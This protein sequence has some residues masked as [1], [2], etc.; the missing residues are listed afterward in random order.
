MRAKGVEGLGGLGFKAIRGS[1]GYGGLW[2]VLG[3][4]VGC[5]F[6]VLWFSVWG[7]R[8]FGVVWFRE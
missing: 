8:V 2:G 1:W 6:R 4:D 5:G 3:G 7:F